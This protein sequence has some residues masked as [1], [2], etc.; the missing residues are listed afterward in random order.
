M[1]TVS[2]YVLKKLLATFV[3]TTL[4][5]C[6]VFFV[7][8]SFRLL[9][10]EDLS[11]AQVAMALPWVV[12]FLL[13]Y[14]IP[15]AYMSTLT[16][17][18]GRLVADNEVLAFGSLGIRARTL[19]WPA[20]WLALALTLVCSWLTAQVVPYCH[21]QKQMAARA[22]FQQLFH[23]GHGEHWSRTFSSQGFDLYVRRY[24]PGQL[25]GIVIHYVLRKNDLT[26][27]GRG[28]S[29]QLVAKSGR[30]AEHSE[31]Q[32]LVLVLEDVTV[33]LAL[34]ADPKDM[35]TGYEEVDKPGTPPEIK[36]ELGE[37]E[38]SRLAS[39]EP[40]RLHLERYEQAIALG[41]VRRIKETDYGSG[42]LL[43]A[44][45]MA[46]ARAGLAALTGGLTSS[47]T[48]MDDRDTE[49]GMELAMRGVLSLAALLIT[50][51]VLPVTLMLR[52]RSPLVPFGLG[53][54]ATAT[55]FFGPVLLGR[56]L[57]DSTHISD[58]VYLGILIPLLAGAALSWLA[59]RR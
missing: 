54:A 34:A 17:V 49:A 36:E 14:L 26:G 32:R 5:L 13:P 55:L 48:A 50:L 59:A 30:I 51:I 45:H 57:A 46:Q 33:T 47:L 12:P 6:F 37:E 31:T 9:R 23:L 42:D 39:D 18:Y 25:E 2:R 28:L 11:L 38:R 20:L 8:A 40:I 44:R 41:G 1:S 29:T 43:R 4:G 27:D 24:R 58:F 15:M 10:E 16:L 7:G 56:S 21:Q 22:V 19:C 3:P 35:P 52:A 53:L